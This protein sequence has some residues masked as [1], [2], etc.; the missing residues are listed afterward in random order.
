MSQS[1]I[2]A[3]REVDVSVE[4]ARDWFL[5]LRDH[6]ERYRFETHQGIEFVRGD[7]GEVGTRFKTREKFY[8]LR[9]ELLFEL[10][11]VGKA[12]FRFRLI[13][14]APLQVWGAFN[15]QELGPERVLLRLEIGSDAEL[16]RAL[17]N[18]SPI[19]AAV[20]GQIT[21][22]VVHIKGSMES[23]SRSDRE[24]R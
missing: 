15:V 11:E 23:L 2:S 19:K 6:P 12:W 24:T 5:S 10:I 22:E 17:F 7:F 4:E 1:I 9:L 3:Q 18:F 13:S 20:R 16:G 14:L 21:G 8:F